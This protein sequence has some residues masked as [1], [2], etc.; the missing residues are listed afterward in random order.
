MSFKDKV[1]S[2]VTKIMR[3]LPGGELRRCKNISPMNT[4]CIEH[5]GHRGKCED[6]W[7]YNWSS[8]DSL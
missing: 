3:Q 1:S 8:K 2:L 5:L 4:D 6:A 7:F